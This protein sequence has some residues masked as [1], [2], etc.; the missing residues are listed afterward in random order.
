MGDL[1]FTDEFSTSHRDRRWF[2]SNPIYHNY[3]RVDWEAT[4]SVDYP[5][6]VAIHRHHF[7]VVDTPI[8]VMIRRFVK[9]QCVGDV[10]CHIRKM[11][12]MSLR[13]SNRANGTEI[14]YRTEIPHGYYIF[15]FE[16]AE[17]AIKFALCF[18]D[19][20]S[21]IEERHPEY[22]Y[23]SEEEIAAAVANPYL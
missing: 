19:V 10:I 18:S 16:G 3:T 9:K 14:R 6:Q 8:R 4:I 12:Y 2:F 21:K 13:I 20:V 1:I 22:S 23:I 17:D 5:E 11:D 7:E 15:F